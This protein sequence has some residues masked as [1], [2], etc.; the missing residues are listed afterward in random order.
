MIRDVRIITLMI[1]LLLVG[2]VYPAGYGVGQV[3]PGVEDTTQGSS[4]DQFISSQLETGNDLSVASGWVEGGM[5]I[6]EVESMMGPPKMIS[7]GYEGIII[8]WRDYR[9]DDG[10]IYGQRIGPY[11]EILWS[12]DGEALIVANGIQSGVTAIADG[13]GGAYLAWV[14]YH[15]DYESKAYVQRIDGTGNTLWQDGGIP[16]YSPSQRQLGPKLVSDGEGGII[17]LW[18]AVHYRLRAQRFNI[19]GERLW[20]EG[21]VNITDNPIS[22]GLYRICPSGGGAVVVTWVTSGDIDGWKICARGL[23]SDGTLAWG[24]EKTVVTNPYSYIGFDACEASDGGIYVVWGESSLY[25]TRFWMKVQ[26]ITGDGTSAWIDA[27]VE[28]CDQWYRC[29]KPII[30]EG[31]GGEVFVVWELIQGSKIWQYAQ[32]MNSDGAIH[33]GGTGLVVG[34]AAS[35]LERFKAI[36]DGHGGVISAW[37]ENRDPGQYDIIAQHFDSEG[38]YHWTIIGLRV[39]SDE[40]MQLYPSILADGKGGAFIAWWD[41]KT[42]GNIHATRVDYWGELVPGLFN[43]YTAR[44]TDQTI[45]LNWYLTQTSPEMRFRVS[46]AMEPDWDFIL[47]PDA[48]I[49]ASWSSFSFKDTGL[50]PGTAYRY[51]V[52]ILYESGSR[53]L[54]TTDPITTASLPVTLYRNS[55]NP[56]NYGTEIRFYIPAPAQVRLCVYDISGRIIAN[57][58]NQPK[59]SGYYLEHWDGRNDSGTRIPPGV[60]FLSLTANDESTSR[61]I[62]ILPR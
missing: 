5:P 15:P 58:L 49:S 20:A 11:G 10:D 17:V 28:A 2:L 33:W 34:H 52:D 23:E 12:I 37:Y 43:K 53:E 26:K 57:I 41:G 9:N 14:D 3:Y 22:S 54:F 55:P 50:M 24:E 32:K 42:G 29:R 19:Y 4:T 46:R 44:V 21:G 47:I 51:R 35:Y 31:K 18:Q 39:T 8:I 30:L 13:E 38:V 40:S 45:V 6:C 36:H 27:G 59:E 1:I 7:D 61:K 62:V 56:F 16:V 48:H 60:Y 25:A